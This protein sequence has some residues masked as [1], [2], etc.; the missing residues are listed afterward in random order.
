MRGLLGYLP[1][2]F[3]L[4][5]RVSADDMLDHFAALKGIPGGRRREVV[6][7]LLRQTNLSRREARSWAASPAG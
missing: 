7:G 2:E 4:Y 6:T 3:G 1:Q 5:P